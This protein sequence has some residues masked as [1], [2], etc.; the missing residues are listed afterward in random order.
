M[1]SETQLSTVL[2]ASIYP[3]AQAHDEIESASEGNIPMLLA[4]LCASAAL[5]LLGAAVWFAGKFALSALGA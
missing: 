5:A 4:A 1:N 3:D 2:P